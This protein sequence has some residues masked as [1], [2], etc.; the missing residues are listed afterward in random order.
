MGFDHIIL[1]TKATINILNNLHYKYK[2]IVAVVIYNPQ[3]ILASF[4]I[5]M[6]KLADH[7][8]CYQLTR[9]QHYLDTVYCKS[10]EVEHGFW[11][12]ASTVKLIQ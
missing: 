4:P 8:F 5:N 10:F 6:E 12:S 1:N 11:E 9:G 2:A 3:P 7:I